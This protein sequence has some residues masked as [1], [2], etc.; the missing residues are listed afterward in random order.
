[1][2]HKILLD[3]ELKS[4]S[5]NKAFRGEEGKSDFEND[6]KI[7]RSLFEN[8]PVETVIVDRKARVIG[9]NHAKKKRDEKLPRIS[10]VMYRDYA[11]NHEINMLEELKDCLKTGRSKEL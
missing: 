9:Y 7:F 4:F 5:K 10:D 11:G 1:M 2:K 8:N 3:N 6:E